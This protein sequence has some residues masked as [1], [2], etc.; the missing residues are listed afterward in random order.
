MLSD[1]YIEADLMEE[2]MLNYVQPNHVRKRLSSGYKLA[3]VNF[4]TGR[5]FN[6]KDLSLIRLCAQYNI[7]RGI[8]EALGAKQRLNNWLSK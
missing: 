5:L 7:L 1:T 2:S 6:L 3:F 8:K 4:T